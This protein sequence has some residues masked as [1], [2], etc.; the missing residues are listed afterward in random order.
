MIPDSGLASQLFGKALAGRLQQQ[1]CELL[2]L[3]ERGT[4]GKRNFLTLVILS[5]RFFAK[6]MD[7]G[8]PREKSRL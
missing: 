3:S 1:A 6:R 7:M 5:E 2:I 8:G 4:L